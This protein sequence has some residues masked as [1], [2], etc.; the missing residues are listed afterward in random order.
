V[1]YMPESTSEYTNYSRRIE[2]NT[3]RQL[4]RSLTNL[5][6]ILASKSPTSTPPSPPP[7]QEESQGGEYLSESSGLSFTEKPPGEISKSISM[8]ELNYTASKRSPAVL[9]VSEGSESIPSFQ[10]GQRISPD[11]DSSGSCEYMREDVVPGTI[12]Y[13][14][15][16]DSTESAHVPA[17]IPY[18]SDD[19]QPSQ[20][21]LPLD[22]EEPTGMLS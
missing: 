15:G 16:E 17:T 10:C 13:V 18:A 4:N 8:E 9:E 22:Q 7:T 3:A 14:S 12:P 2:M 11:S 6:N 1:Y 5:S 21:G 20:K 19:D